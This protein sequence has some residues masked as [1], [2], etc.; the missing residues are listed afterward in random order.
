MT[1]KLDQA[2][3][4]GESYR[5]CNQVVIDNP[6]GGA[7]TV[8]FGQETIIGTGGGHTAHIPLSP[9][10]MA[11]SAGGVVPIVNPATGEATGA[12]VSHAEIYALI[13]S[14]YLAAAN[15]APADEVAP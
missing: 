1:Y 13:Y 8:T 12:S 2:P 10:P 9:L 15:S 5:R 3:L 14:A 7:P 11:F 4:A 6:L